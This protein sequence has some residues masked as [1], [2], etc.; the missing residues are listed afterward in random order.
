MSLETPYVLIGPV[1]IDVDSILTAES[2]GNPSIYA[3]AYIYPNSIG[4]VLSLGDVRLQLPA[5]PAQITSMFVFEP[6]VSNVKIAPCESSTQ[7][8]PMLRAIV[9]FNDVSVSIEET[10]TD[11]E[12]AFL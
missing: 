12:I 9:R 4:S 3:I 7:A 8:V 5:I 6:C 1:F 2:Y 11:S 10:N